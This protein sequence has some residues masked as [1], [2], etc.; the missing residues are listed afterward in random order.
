MG[1]R[2]T[3][4]RLKALAD[5]VTRLRIPVYASH[6]CFFLVLSAFPM[7]VL[8]LVLLRYTGLSV[9]VLTD[10]AALVIPEALL[11]TAKGLIL[12]AY[13]NTAGTWIPVSLI[14]AL[15]SSSRGMH[16]LM[17]GLNA[18]YHVTENRGYVATKLLSIGYTL[19][20]LLML[21]MTLVFHVFDYTVLDILQPDGVVGEILS[22]RFFVL[23]FLQTALFT[24][25]Y[26]ALPN[27][28]NRFLDSLPGAV[29][30]ST[31]WLI[32]SDLYSRYVEHFT[33]YTDIYGS[34]YALALA[35]LW[36]YI[37]VSILFYGGALNYAMTAK[38]G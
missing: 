6:A 2:R 19:L 8:L 13:R 25:M 38:R 27:R 34:V 30:S 12:S 18:V 33:G 24:G 11:P 20:M 36:L 29:L 7:L 14:V 23:L 21:L 3:I 5:Y 26:M 15:W 4:H 31:V 17:T 22:L 9:T 1:K 35:M 32:F 37:C 28:K 16:G 10:F